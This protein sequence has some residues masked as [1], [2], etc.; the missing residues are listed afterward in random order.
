MAAMEESMAAIL[1][2]VYECARQLKEAGFT[3]QQAEAQA[4]IMGQAFVHNVDQLVTRDYLDARLTQLE[5][6]LDGRITRLEGKVQLL[7]WGQG[8]TIAAVVLPQLRQ[9][10][11]G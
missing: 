2:D 8:L 5:S 7:Y 1:F 10:L 4:R 6:R 3:E 9:F 11:A